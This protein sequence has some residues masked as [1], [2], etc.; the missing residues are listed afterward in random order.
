MNDQELLTSLYKETWQAMVNKDEKKLRELHDDSFVL[1]H[2]TGMKQPYEVFISAIMNGDLNYYSTRHD[3]IGIRIDGDQAH[4]KGQ[5]YVLAAVFGGGKNY[6][7]LQLDFT[8]EKKDG[9]WVNTYCV[10]S[11]Y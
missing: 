10:A 1:V 3:H 9:R 5:T 2:M 7:H 6:W 4:I 8:C 11:T